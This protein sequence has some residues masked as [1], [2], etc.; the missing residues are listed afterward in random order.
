MDINSRAYYK[1]HLVMW[2]FNPEITRNSRKG[3]LPVL[4]RWPSLLKMWLS[5]LKMWLVSQ[6]YN[7]KPGHIVWKPGHFF[8]KP[9][10]IFRKLSWWV[11]KY[12]PELISVVK[13]R[14]Y[15][16]IKFTAPLMFEISYSRIYKLSLFGISASK[17]IVNRK[18]NKKTYFLPEIFRMLRNSVE[19][20]VTL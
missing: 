3:S 16:K 12:A 17:G 11:L 6:K 7:R 4:I 2:N 13:K 5:F 18:I 10:H 15:S 20:L 9:G 19:P 14:K 1:S 8:R